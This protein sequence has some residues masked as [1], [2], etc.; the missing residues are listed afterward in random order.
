M[1]KEDNVW[2]ICAYPNGVEGMAKIVK[3]SP[4]AQG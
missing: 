4:N 1:L 2:L 3:H